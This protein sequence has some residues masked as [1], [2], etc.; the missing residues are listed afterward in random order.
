MKAMTYTEA[1]EKL[2]D[3]IQRV[4]DDHELAANRQKDLEKGKRAHQSDRE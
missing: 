2:A 3:T 4:C 1:R